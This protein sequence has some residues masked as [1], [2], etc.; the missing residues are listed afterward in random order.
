MR[1]LVV[2]FFYLFVVTC[3]AETAAAEALSSG[4]DVVTYVTSKINENDVSFSTALTTM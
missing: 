4:E 2:F 1:H 3:F